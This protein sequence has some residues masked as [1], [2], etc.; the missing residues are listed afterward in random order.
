M[1]V[2]TGASPCNSESAL[3][4][5]K[6][7]LSKKNNLA[8]HRSNHPIGGAYTPGERSTEK[9]RVSPVPNHRSCGGRCR[10]FCKS[11]Y[12]ESFLG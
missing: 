8:K 9:E 10:V 7:N 6:N 2:L 11:K 3:E 5:K 12:E 1:L 4:N